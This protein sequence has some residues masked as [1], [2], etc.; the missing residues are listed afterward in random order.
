MTCVDCLTK[1]IGRCEHYHLQ[2]GP[3]DVVTCVDCLATSS[4]LAYKAMGKDALD[5]PTWTGYW[6]GVGPDGLA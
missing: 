6:H 4:R 5:A 3:G 1:T 2:N